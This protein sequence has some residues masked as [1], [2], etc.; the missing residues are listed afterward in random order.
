MPSLRSTSRT[1]CEQ[2]RRHCT[3]WC[4]KSS[5]VTSTW[6]TCRP[7]RR[8]RPG[9]PA[10]HR[11]RR[12]RSQ[13][14]N[15]SPPSRHSLLLRPSKAAHAS[16]QLAKLLEVVLREVLASANFGDP[17]VEVCAHLRA[18]LGGR[19]GDLSVVLRLSPP[20]VTETHSS[21]ARSALEITPPTNLGTLGTSDIVMRRPERRLS[22][23]RL[24][25]PHR[26]WRL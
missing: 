25:M 5:R 23:R 17:A 1:M 6:P 15:S 4:Q 11:R 22:G 13:S 14:R 10:T 7:Q 24:V 3:R 8:T 16:H 2:S 26:C 20:L 9:L 12:R 21:L 19:A 18:C